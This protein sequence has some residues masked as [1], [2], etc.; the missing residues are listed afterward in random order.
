MPHALPTC[1]GSPTRHGRTYPPKRW[2]PDGDSGRVLHMAT[3]YRSAERA[4]KLSLRL[5]VHEVE[6]LR[7]A[8]AD[9]GYASVQQLIEARV[10]G[11][12][13]PRRKPGPKPQSEQLGLSA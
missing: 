7:R 12:A 1:H 5:S 3:D 2:S 13:R 8:A 11:E 6:E 10:F 9:E 4:H